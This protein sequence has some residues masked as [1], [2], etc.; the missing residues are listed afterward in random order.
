VLYIT[1]I[2]PNGNETE[3]MRR[4]LS[5]D[6]LSNRVETIAEAAENRYVWFVTND[7]FD[8]SVREQFDVLVQTYR[9]EQVIGDCKPEWCYLAQLMVAPPQIEPVV[10]GDSLGF[11]GAD[12]EITTSTIEALLW[13]SVDE[14]PTQD[15][16][17]SLQLLDSSDTLVTQVDR[18]IKPPNYDE[19][20][21]SQMQPNN[22]YIDLRELPLPE[23]LADGEYL[24][25]L[26]VY[27]WQDNTR[28]TLPDG[29]DTLLIQNISME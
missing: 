29:R 14:Q 5:A 11:H 9:V 10:F 24:L 1:H 21:T 18:Q 28:L 3:L 2:D 4:Y 16:S 27:Q 26:V 20:P 17:I 7:W 25:Q 12:V 13:W 22:S 19:I 15:Y 8:D 23:N 6:I